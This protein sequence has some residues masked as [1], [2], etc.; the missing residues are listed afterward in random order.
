VET[1]GHCHSHT[2]G[3]GMQHDETVRKKKD[4]VA[5]KLLVWVGCNDPA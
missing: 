2:V 3:H 5:H 1:T 4:I